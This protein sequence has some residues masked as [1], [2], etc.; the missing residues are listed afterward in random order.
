MMTP[1]RLCHVLLLLRLC[2]GMVMCN[3]ISKPQL[4]T[5]LLTDQYNQCGFK[6]LMYKYM[7]YCFIV[8]IIY[9]V[10]TSHSSLEFFWFASLAFPA[11][12]KYMRSLDS[13]FPMM[14]FIGMDPQSPPALRLCT[15]MRNIPN[16]RD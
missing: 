4:L 10:R 2:L 8:V 9:Q 7:K 6:C 3:H 5:A 13:G 1:K 14:L 16:L 12:A 15:D 11:V